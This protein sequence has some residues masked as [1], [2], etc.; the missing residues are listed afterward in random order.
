MTKLS[1]PKIEIINSNLSP[2]KQAKPGDAGYDLRAMIK[3]KIWLYPHENTVIPTGIKM[4]IKDH[5]IAGLI[6]SRS[7]RG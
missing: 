7:R 1:V 4:H 2:L 6:L 3:E 5:Y